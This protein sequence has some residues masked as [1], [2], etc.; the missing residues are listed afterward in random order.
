[1]LKRYY[2]SDRGMSPDFLSLASDEFDENFLKSEKNY[3]RSPVKNVRF[4]FPVETCDKQFAGMLDHRVVY[5]DLR[6]FINDL[7]K[8]LRKA[9]ERL[10][11]KDKYLISHSAGYDSQIMS[12]TLMGM[13]RD[14]IDLGEIHFR[15]YEPECEPFKLIMR[16]QG[17][18]KDEYSC[19]KSRISDPYKITEQFW[20]DNHVN[21]FANWNQVMNYWWDIISDEKDY[22][23]VSGIGGEV[24]K[25]LLRHSSPPFNYCTNRAI[26]YLYGYNHGFGEWQMQWEMKFKDHLMPYFSYEWLDVVSKVNEKHLKGKPDNIRPLLLDTLRGLRVKRMR[27]NYNWSISEQQKRLV[28]DWWDGC[29]LNKRYKIGKIPLEMDGMNSKLLGFANVYERIQ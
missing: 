23:I 29:K 9:L 22:I 5:N 28:R 26:N 2:I 7:K 3:I 20:G 24:F 4:T 14:G 6:V 15:C 27:H 10:W 11:K 8:A 19:F 1:M 16:S 21:G 17:W 12:Q 25:Y 18:R 13:R